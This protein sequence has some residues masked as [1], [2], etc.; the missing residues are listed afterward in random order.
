MLFSCSAHQELDDKTKPPT[1]Q[2]GGLTGG[3][4]V[5][6]SFLAAHRREISHQAP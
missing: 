2:G 3:D 1:H 6:A 5:S 4:F